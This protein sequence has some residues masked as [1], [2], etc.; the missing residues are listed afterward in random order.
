MTTHNKKSDYEALNLVATLGAHCLNPD[1]FAA[2]TTTLDIIRASV[3]RRVKDEVAEDLYLTD[4][5]KLRFLT[6][7][8]AGPHTCNDCG[9]TTPEVQW[10]ACPYAEE[11][12]GV[13]DPVPLC[14]GCADNR[15]MEI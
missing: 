4:D 1:A 12:D 14:P 3:G 2:L 6:D 15:A 10:M 7:P 8:P 13:V 5:E 9:C 11:I